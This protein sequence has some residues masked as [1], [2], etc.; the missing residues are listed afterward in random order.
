[1]IIHPVSFLRSHPMKYSSLASSSAT[2]HLSELF[3]Q[4]DHLEIRKEEGHK[5]SKTVFQD[6]VINA[7]VQ[8]CL[9]Q[10]RVI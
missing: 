10:R 9:I 3:R 8:I 4:S 5:A 7:L 1:M 2:D 6:H